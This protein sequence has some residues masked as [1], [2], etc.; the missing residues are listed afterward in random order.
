[1]LPANTLS[2]TV[3]STGNDSP[4][5]G[6]PLPGRESS[7]DQLKSERVYRELRRR[8]RELEL[9]PGARLRKDEI[10]VEADESGETLFVLTVRFR[11]ARAL[12]VPAVKERLFSVGS[13]VVASSP[14]Q[15][16]AAIRS[17][18]ARIR[19]LIQ[20]AGLREQ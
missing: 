15:A 20:D 12:H 14:A 11:P 16:A 6:L 13:E 10:A 9:P 7:N 5:T 3:F 4:V 19:K 1:M 17:E 18:T 2:P 8:I